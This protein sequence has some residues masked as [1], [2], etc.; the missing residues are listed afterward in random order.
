MRE[1]E[2]GGREREGE[3][4]RM[5]GEGERKGRERKREDKVEYIAKGESFIISYCNKPEA[6]EDE[7]LHACLSV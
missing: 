4:K 6:D 3:R 1:E 2:E 5:G 7:V